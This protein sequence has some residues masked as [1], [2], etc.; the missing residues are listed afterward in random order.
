M[1]SNCIWEF[2][3]ESTNDRLE[4]SELKFS[5]KVEGLTE[6]VEFT[7]LTVL[8]KPSVMSI[9]KNMTAQKEDPVMVAIA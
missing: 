1:S 9:K 8:S 2:I 7:V 5:H 4:T 6:T 3:T